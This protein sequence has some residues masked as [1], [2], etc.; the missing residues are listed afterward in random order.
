MV[1]KKLINMVKSVTHKGVSIIPK[2]IETINL[3]SKF[4]STKIPTVK[5]KINDSII[6]DRNDKLTYTCPNCQNEIEILVGKFLKKESENCR[7]CKEKDI[8]KRN[9]QSEYIKKSFKEFNR[10]VGKNRDIIKFGDLT[11]EQLIELSDKLFSEES[12]EFKSDYIK[13]TIS[14]NEFNSIRQFIIKIGGIDIVDNDDIKYFRFIKNTNQT[15]YSCK[16][17]V[18]DR[19]HLLDKCEFICQMCNDKFTGRNILN[20]YNNGILCRDCS[21]SNKTFKFKY[22]LNINGD[23][24]VYQSSPEL[25]LIKHYNSMGI[26]IKNGPRI[27]YNFNGKERIYKVDFEVRSNKMLIEV[28]DMHIWH[29][30]EV[31][32]GKWEAKELAARK[33]CDENEYLFYLIHNVDVIIYQ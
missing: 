24:V 1:F 32:S 19:L 5:I 20:K 3:L 29:R 4:S 21:F 22:T 28:K 25:K 8:D 13:K 23:K 17:L 16:V 12:L 11:T 7:V 18:N 14:E 27:E 15:K 2:N 9:K 26:L 6:L 31:E 10:V 30:K 33:W